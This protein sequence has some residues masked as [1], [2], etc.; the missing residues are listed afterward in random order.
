MQPEL[1]TEMLRGLRRND[2]RIVEGYC[3]EDL[4]VYQRINRHGIYW[5]DARY[6]WARFAQETRRENF[7][8]TMH[9]FDRITVIKESCVLNAINRLNMEQ[10]TQILSMIAKDM[11]RSSTQNDVGD[12]RISALRSDLQEDRFLTFQ[13]LALRGKLDQIA[14]PETQKQS[15][16]LC[17]AEELLFYYGSD[18]SSME[19]HDVARME[20]EC[21]EEPDEESEFGPAWLEQV[22]EKHRREKL[23]EQR[24]HQEIMQAWRRIAPQEEAVLLEKHNG[25]NL[26]IEAH[27]AVL[28]RKMLLWMKSRHLEERGGECLWTY[29]DHTASIVPSKAGS[30]FSEKI[31]RGISSADQEA[32]MENVLRN[33]DYNCYWRLEELTSRMP[34]VEKYR[35]A[36]KLASSVISLL[37]SLFLW[38]ARKAAARI[39]K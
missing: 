18:A 29:N 31:F 22:I 6:L 24:L 37:R 16:S 36:D 5:H 7:G 4:T 12:E 15:I 21:E 26:K 19:E 1:H 38:Q 8:H 28:R 20:E 3:P 32:L 25:A 33:F 11:E 30:S 39:E 13:D 14:L 10:R 17:D 27:L 9:T 2:R 34:L 23:E 35:W